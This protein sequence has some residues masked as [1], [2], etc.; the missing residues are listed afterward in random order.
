MNENEYNNI[1]T[2]GIHIFRLCDSLVHF[3]P[4]VL[5]TL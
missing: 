1:V 5:K 3:V 4:N 2:W